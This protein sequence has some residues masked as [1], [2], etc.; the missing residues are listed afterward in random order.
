MMANFFTS[1]PPRSSWSLFLS[2]YLHFVSRLNRIAFSFSVSTYA[3][4]KGLK[5]IF[6]VRCARWQN[7]FA[8]SLN[9]YL[10]EQEI[11]A[12]KVQVFYCGICNKRC[13]K[14]KR[15]LLPLLLGN[16]IENIYDS[17]SIDRS[18]NTDVDVPC[19]FQVC[20]TNIW[21]RNFVQ[22]KW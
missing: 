22:F 21:K 19:K 10:I 9:F 14:R 8:C 18:W 13:R 16:L 15:T 12:V 11:F 4:A 1:C 2:L 20:K 5:W 3:N 7:Y 6:T 17:I